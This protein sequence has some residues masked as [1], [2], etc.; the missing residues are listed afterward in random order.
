MRPEGGQGSK[1][2][3]VARGG[4]GAIEGEQ[5]ALGGIDDLNGETGAGRG[6]RA[7]EKSGLDAREQGMEAGIG[8]AIEGA[9]GAV[10]HHIH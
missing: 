4:Q 9:V 5:A 10:R 6:R 2:L 8:E 7:I 1:G 3:G